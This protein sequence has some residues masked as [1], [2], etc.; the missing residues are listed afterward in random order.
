MH[1]LNKKYDFQKCILVNLN[2]APVCS[3]VQKPGTLSTELWCYSIKK[4]E[5]NNSTKSFNRPIVMKYLIE[6]LKY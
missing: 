3:D 4:I 2:K 5:T 6:V 1:F